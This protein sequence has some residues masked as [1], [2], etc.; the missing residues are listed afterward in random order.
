[1]GGKKS[2]ISLVVRRRSTI[3][4]IASE[5]SDK[6]EKLT[7]ELMLQELE[8]KGFKISSR[9]LYEDRLDIAKGNNY[10]RNIAESTYS[11][12]IESIMT[13]LDILES[14]YWEWMKNPPQIKKQKVELAG[15]DADGKPVYKIL[16]SSLETISPVAI[17]KDIREI[18]MAKKE[19][20]SGDVLDLSIVMLAEKYRLIEHQV[21]EAK[22]MNITSKKSV[23]LKLKELPDNANSE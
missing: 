11:E 9:T 21:N 15:K 8:K 3:I 19:V 1:M 17:G 23:K 7:T 10:V 2:P 5:Y 18:V 16:E 22:Q 6:G 14:K 4:K 20:I 13:S 12:Q